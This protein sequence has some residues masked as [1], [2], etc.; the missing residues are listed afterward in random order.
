MGSLYL[1]DSLNKTPLRSQ[2]TAIVKKNHVNFTIHLG[3]Y[4]A[5]NAWSAFLFPSLVLAL[6][7][8]KFLSICWDLCLSLITFGITVLKFWCIRFHDYSVKELTFKCVGWLIVQGKQITWFA[9]STH[10][11]LLQYS[12][13][14]YLH[15][16]LLPLDISSSFCVTLA[17]NHHYKIVVIKILIWWWYFC[18]VLFSKKKSNYSA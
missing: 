17:Y 10:I 3:T 16:Y 1:Y 18:I 2:N 9:F 13:F 6:K 5:F 11:L 8:L 7:K 12:S 15:G 4:Y 14:G